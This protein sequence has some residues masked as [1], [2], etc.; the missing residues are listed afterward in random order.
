[1]SRAKSLL[2]KA[3]HML[4]IRQVEF[5]TCCVLS[6]YAIYEL[7]I[8]HTSITTDLIFVAFSCLEAIGAVLD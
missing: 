8:F 3:W 1:M 7:F 4:P 5:C 2:V 6:S